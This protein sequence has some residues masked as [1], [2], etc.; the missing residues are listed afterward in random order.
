MTLVLLLVDAFFRKEANK[1]NPR[2]FDT[3]QILQWIWLS[4]K[5]CKTSFYSLWMFII[6]TCK[7]H[8]PP[9]PLPRSSISDNNHRRLRPHPPTIWGNIRRS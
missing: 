1:A 8:T 4:N 9:L 5:S 6:F 2:S 7:C 3:T